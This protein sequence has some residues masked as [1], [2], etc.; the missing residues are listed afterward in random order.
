VSGEQQREPQP[1]KPLHQSLSE[2]YAARDAAREQAVQD[3]QQAKPKES[4]Q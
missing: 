3:Q 1:V 2:H 4:V